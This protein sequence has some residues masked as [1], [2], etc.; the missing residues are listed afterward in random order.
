MPA[1]ATLATGTTFPP[2]PADQIIP[3]VTYSLPI[4]AFRTKEE[5]K[6]I[7]ATGASLLAET[8]PPVSNV[9]P[10]NAPK[11]TPSTTSRSGYLATTPRDLPAQDR[12]EYHLTHWAAGENGVSTGRTFSPCRSKPCATPHVYMDETPVPDDR[13]VVSV[14]LPPFS[15]VLG[16]PDQAQRN[17]ARAQQESQD[18]ST[19]RSA[20]SSAT[21]PTLGSPIEVDRFEAA[22]TVWEAHGALV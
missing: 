7:N 14:D 20:V 17:A 3:P 8:R 15:E 18:R 21:A 19:A 4:R 6:R 22:M 12:I 1:T 10:N 16:Y 5:R 13:P 11:A 9:K 2:R